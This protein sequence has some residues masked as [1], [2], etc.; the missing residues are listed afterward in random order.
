VEPGREHYADSPTVRCCRADDCCNSDRTLDKGCI[1]RVWTTALLALGL[2]LIIGRPYAGAQTQ[3]SRAALRNGEALELT[4]FYYISN[5]RSIMIGLP[6]I[7]ILEG[8][9]E[10]SL[11]IKEEQV[12]PRK[13]G[14][15]NKVPGGKLILT[16]KGSVTERT[17]V[18]LFFRLKYRTKDGDRQTSGTYIVTL[19]P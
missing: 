5:C 10:L 7:E 12:V 16:A 14:C 6:E 11:A 1:V 15:V 4:T 13:F 18:N 9:A 17:E 2:A 19:F 3:S 8:S